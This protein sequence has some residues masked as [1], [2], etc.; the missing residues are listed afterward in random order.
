[1]AYTV[2]NAYIKLVKT[3]SSLKKG[4]S[5]TYTATGYGVSTDKITW[6]T[7]RKSIVVINKKTGKATAK[8]AG[9]D[10]VVAKYGSVQKV[11]KVTVK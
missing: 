5:F 8:S 2:Q 7:T 1:M 3:K 11:I 6:T 9:T 10:T 4:E